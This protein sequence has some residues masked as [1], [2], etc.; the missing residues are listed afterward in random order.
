M[1]KVL[2]FTKH[3]MGISSKYFSKVYTPRK[4]SMEEVKKH[5]TIDDCWV[6]INKKVY[7]VTDFLSSHPGGLEILVKSGG[8]D[9]TEEFDMFHFYDTLKKYEDD[10]EF[11]G[12]IEKN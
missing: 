5:H 9:A 12:E 6:V 3:R 7:D 11:L 1:I 4:I 8:T 2:N 10:I